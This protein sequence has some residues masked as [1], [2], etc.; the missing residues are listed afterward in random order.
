VGSNPHWL[1]RGVGKPLKYIDDGVPPKSN[2]A[3]PAG[4]WQN[5]EIVFKAPRFD[6]QGKKTGNA[7][8]LSVTLNH[9]YR[10]KPPLMKSKNL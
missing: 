3:K 2:A 9:Q 7:K 10:H 5:L 6:D 8:F 4:Q 1:F